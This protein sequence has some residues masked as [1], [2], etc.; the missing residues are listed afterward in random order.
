MNIEK[1]LSFIHKTG[2]RAL[3]PIGRMLVKKKYRKETAKSSLAVL[4]R[5]V[6][7]LEDLIARVSD[8]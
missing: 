2:S 4:K 8:K 5:A 3:E 1:E 6:T 7:Q